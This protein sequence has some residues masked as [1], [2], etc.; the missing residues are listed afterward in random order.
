MDVQLMYV[1]LQKAELFQK[2]NLITGLK[3]N[4]FVEIRQN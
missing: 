1:V 4:F 3:V 2:Y